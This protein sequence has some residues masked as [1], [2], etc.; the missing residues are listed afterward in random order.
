MAEFDLLIVGGTFVDGT[1][2]PK[3]TTDVAI[4]AGR[5]AERKGKHPQGK[6]KSSPRT[7]TSPHTKNTPAA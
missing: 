1:L 3:H 2:L 5:I 4:S 7:A 6:A